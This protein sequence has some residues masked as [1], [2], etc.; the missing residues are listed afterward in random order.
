[1]TSILGD[2]VTSS[3]IA[4]DDKAVS[5]STVDNV[6]VVDRTSTVAEDDIP[7]PSR[8]VSK[9]GCSVAFLPKSVGG[10]G[11]VVVLRKLGSSV[12]SVKSVGDIGV[13][14]V[15]ENIV[16]CTYSVVTS[17]LPS[18]VDPGNVTSSVGCLV[19]VMTSVEEAV[20]VASGSALVSFC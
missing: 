5:F 3:G 12:S 8:V 7:L 1:M 17:P 13:T 20:A 18:V 6:D 9:S 2:F 15:V 14:A 11:E 10:V 19:S 4:V 16:V